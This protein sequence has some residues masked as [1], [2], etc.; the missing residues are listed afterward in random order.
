MQGS[1]AKSKGNVLCTLTYF[2][3]VA[4]TRQFQQVLTARKNHTMELIRACSGLNTSS[5]GS[6][7]KRLGRNF[8]KK[9]GH[10]VVTSIPFLQASNERSNDFGKVAWKQ[11]ERYYRH[12]LRFSW[13]DFT[14]QLQ[15]GARSRVAKLS[16]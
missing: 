1:I 7:L 14:L 12:L 6:F 8:L 4:Q 5:P 13:K 10:R 9:A 16:S 3:I 11:S 15:P 2:L